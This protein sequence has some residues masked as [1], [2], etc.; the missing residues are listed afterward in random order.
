MECVFVQKNTSDECTYAFSYC[1]LRVCARSKGCVP[2]K[3]HGRLVVVFVFCFRSLYFGKPLG[4][5]TLHEP[6]TL[7]RARNRQLD[8]VETAAR[9]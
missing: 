2:Y 3:Y 5:T 7:R 9:K 6:S 8:R 4:N 1:V